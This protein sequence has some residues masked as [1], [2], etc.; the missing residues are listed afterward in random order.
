[1]VILLIPAP[2]WSRENAVS[3]NRKLETGVWFL[4][5]S[6]RRFNTVGLQVFST[7][8]DKLPWLI[9]ITTFKLHLEQKV[10]PMG[11]RGIGQ[12]PARLVG[13]DM[14]SAHTMV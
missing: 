12:S 8:H 4:A 2:D 1:M 9:Y 6:E 7:Y 5:S 13:D 11:R 3:V 14:V 10:G